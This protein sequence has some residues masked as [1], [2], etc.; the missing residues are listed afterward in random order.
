MSAWAPGEKCHKLC[1]LHP[2]HLFPEVLEAGNS[3]TSMSVGK[4]SG[5]FC[6][7]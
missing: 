4:V 3:K 7:H 6:G 5:L 2:R 1:G